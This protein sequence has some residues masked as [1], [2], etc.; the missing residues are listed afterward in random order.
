MS[1]NIRWSDDDISDNGQYVSD[2]AHQRGHDCEVCNG[3]CT[4]I[5]GECTACGALDAGEDFDF[6]NYMENI[7]EEFSSTLDKLSKSGDIG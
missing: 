4:V 5:E 2:F 7:G 1:E 6:E 3:Y